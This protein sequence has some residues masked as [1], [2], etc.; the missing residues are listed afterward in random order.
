M[1]ISLL[2]WGALAAPPAAPLFTQGKVPVQTG[3]EGRLDEQ[4]A[5]SCGLCHEAI[6]A[7]WRKSRHAASWT[8]G[9]FQTEYRQHPQAWCVNCHAPTVDQ[10]AQ[11]QA[12]GGAFADEG[13]TCVTCHVRDGQM[14]ARRRRPDSIHDTV[15]RP[16][17]GDPDFCGGC[18]QF[19]FPIFG[20]KGEATAF[21][22]HPM[23]RTVAQF[24][25]GPYADQPEGCRG[26]HS[27]GG[28]GHL[29]PGA[30]DPQML[31]KA[32]SLIFCRLDGAE[33][34]EQGR[35]RIGVANVGAGHNVPTGDVHR[36]MNARLWRS[37]APEQMF[38]VFIG[39]R[40]EVAPGGGKRVTWDSTIPPKRRRQFSVDPA[41]LGGDASEPIN[42]E[43]RYVY[44]LE[45]WPRPGYD[46][47]EPMS[48]V[49][50]ADRRRFE[51]IPRCEPQ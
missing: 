6:Y 47:G 7:E 13:V 38:E 4:K 46:P 10:V 41:K 33:G 44:T 28:S 35:V 1:W 26:C 9:I 5:E 14:T 30:H 21:T 22:A 45:E 50:Q 29:Y 51:D 17:F 2:L 34:A 43:L 11:V 48:H 19:N 39:R 8:N 15:A 27:E 49:V 25:A 40:F 3:L 20:P 36:H 18:H 24:K 12:G 16:D 42:V 37:S 23:Q 31:S 32:L